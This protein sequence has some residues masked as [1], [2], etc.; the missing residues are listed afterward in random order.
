M[1][2]SH[3]IRHRI[4]T[5]QKQTAVTTRRKK[6]MNAM[7]GDEDEEDELDEDDIGVHT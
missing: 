5:N 4:A 2:N 7:D 1:K 6:Y 3:A